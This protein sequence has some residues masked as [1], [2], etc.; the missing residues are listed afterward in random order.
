[1]FFIFA[2]AILSKEKEL[3]CNL[4]IL[5]F[6]VVCVYIHNVSVIPTV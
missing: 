5:V 2:D 4:G 6:N 3:A 1:M